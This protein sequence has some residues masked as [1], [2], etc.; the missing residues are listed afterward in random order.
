MKLEDEASFLKAEPKVG[1][2]VK[3]DTDLMGLKR[4]AVA[5]AAARNIALPSFVMSFLRL[6]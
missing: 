1:A 5:Q 4:R 6:F 2:E 3:A